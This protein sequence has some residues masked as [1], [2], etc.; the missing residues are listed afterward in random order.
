MC[1]CRHLLASG[2]FFSTKVLTFSTSTLF[3][4]LRDLFLLPSSLESAVQEAIVQKCAAWATLLALFSH[5]WQHWV[6]SL[7]TWSTFPSLLITVLSCVC[8]CVYCRHGDAPEHKHQPRD[9]Q[10]PGNNMFLKQPK[11]FCPPGKATMEFR[12]VW[13]SR[14]VL[15]DVS[16]R[17]PGE[18]TEKPTNTD[19]LQIVLH[20]ACR[21]WMEVGWLMST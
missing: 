15:L 19:G 1:R 10:K 6:S 4:F 14:V 2:G 7:S 5:L 16:C 20:F 18:S 9:L 3:S 13:K 17:V 12:I 11:Y 8:A 21:Y